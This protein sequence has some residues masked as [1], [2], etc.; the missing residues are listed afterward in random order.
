MLVNFFLF[1]YL[2]ALSPRLFSRKKLY[3]F[4]RLFGSIP[5]V[6]GDFVIWIHA[7]SV[8]EVKAA[9]PLFKALRQAHP[10]SYILVT[11]TTATGQMEAKNSLPDADAYRF[12]PLDFSWNVRRW[13]KKL[14]PKFFFLMESDIWPNLL[15]ELKKSGAKTVLVSG[16]MSERSFRR[17]LFFSYFSKK[18]FS[19]F[20][21]ICA[22]NEENKKRFLPFIS[23]SSKLEI[24]GNIKLDA[25]PIPVDVS[26][27]CQKLNLPS[28][29]VVCSC[30]H[31]GEEELILENF[32][33]D[34]YFLI[35]VPR[36]PERF[37]EVSKLLG[38]KKI[39]FFLWSQLEKRRGDERVL[40]VD[41]MGKL[42]I[43]YSL[44]RL[45]ILG[46]SY[47]DK[48]G[49]HNILEPSLYGVPVFFGPY[50]FNQ[51][52]LVSHVLK[53][54]AGKQLPLSDLISSINH[55][56]DHLDEEIS[57]RESA[58]FL[59]SSRRGVVDKTLALLEEK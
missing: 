49:G 31:A 33:L 32:P 51:L 45:A 20:S 23:K 21:L 25:D 10:Q 50:M 53:A 6:R 36:H 1:F 34:R 29:T 12:L 4:E 47:V 16:K 41:A 48:I 26:F 28:K 59:S 58:Q 52:D 37:E 13:V 15:L 56:F 43:I 27:W 11:T 55:F 24:T 9:Q 18:I 39:P 14:K 44:S 3:L 46:G 35:L 38:F 42:P 54:K 57:M 22:Q 7:V 5:S 8:G 30:T 17:F 19:R 40:L 2:L